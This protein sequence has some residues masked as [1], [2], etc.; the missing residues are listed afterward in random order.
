MSK[1]IELLARGV[2]VRDG[3]VLLCHNLKKK[4]YFL[5]GGHIE[6]GE[7]AR[8]ALQREIREE[9]GLKNTVGR[10]LG[11]SEHT[12]RCKGK[13]VCEINIV[14]EFELRGV[15]A[16]RPVPSAEKKLEFI[17]FP[18]RKLSRSRIEPFTMKKDL[19]VWLKGRRGGHW[20]SSY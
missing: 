7:S 14:F 2:L 17:W 16:S 9:T 15:R 5:P 19:S 4:N 11:A 13:R 10:F 1:D 6:F 8:G 18:L 3:H 20:G 12:F